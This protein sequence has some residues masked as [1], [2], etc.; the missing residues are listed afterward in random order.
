ML[1][2]F[3]VVAGT[4]A[5]NSPSPTTADHG[6]AYFH[7][8]IREIPWSIHVF[9]LD[10]SRRDFVFGTTLGGGN[11]FGMTTVS[12]Q[13]KGLPTGLGTPVAAV[14]GD[15]YSND[16]PYQGDPRDLQIHQGELVSAPNGHACFWVNAAGEPQSTNV[17]SRFQ[18]KWSD[19]T[20]S[21]FGLNEARE[22]NA[23]VLYTAINGASTRTT[24]GR[25]LIL[26][27]AHKGGWLPLRVGQTFQARIRAVRT[28]GNSELS[29]DTM[30]LS[31]GPKLATHLANTA[32]GSL[33]S[34]TTDTFPSLV[35]VTTAIGGGPTLVRRGLPMPWSGLLMRHPRTA[36]GWNKDHYF[37]VEVDGR[38]SNL[39]VGMTF[40]ELADYMA[41]LGCDEA[42]NLDGG[43]SATMWVYGNI[44]NSPSEGRER[45]GANSLVIFHKSDGTQ[46]RHHP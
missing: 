1:A 3:G 2:G 25:E 22:A 32:P 34:L 43:G 44:M 20:T 13:L 28:E 24:G 17:I 15:F 11:S 16:N 36:L 31:L 45:P 37:L 9:K 33:V 12:E 4:P 41:K 14:N 26:E 46:A 42:M 5:T 38:Q 35:G 10:R 19:G 8:A 29:P 30:V 27:N 39:S 40:P 7:E 6:Y 23:A 18:V 21:L